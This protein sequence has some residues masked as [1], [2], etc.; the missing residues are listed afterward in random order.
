M[1]NIHCILLSGGTGARMNTDI[2]KQFL[3]IGNETI[4]YRTVSV[5][6]EWGLS[7]SC[8]IVVNS[9]YIEKSENEL[10]PIL[11]EYDRIVIGGNTRHKSVIAGLSSCRYD[12]NDVIIFH[13][14]AR[15]FVTKED[16]DNIVHSTLQFGAATLI[17]EISETLVRSEK[18]IVQ[19]IIERN[20]TYLVKTPQAIHA[21]AL[22]ELMKIDFSNE[23]P[24]DLCSWVLKI[25]LKPVQVNSNPYNIKI[26]KK[27]DLDLAHFLLPLI[28]KKS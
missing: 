1:N 22:K 2:P 9:D 3:K 5:F 8:V 18:N 23:D 15:P 10:S 26:T 4:L 27:E 14:V 11:D 7:K 19:D 21:S 25:G 28:Q 24:T 6:K 16:L 20:T 13:D 12:E 17:G